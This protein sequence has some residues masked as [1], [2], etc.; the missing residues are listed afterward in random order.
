MDAAQEALFREVEEDLRSEQ[1][2]RL[3]KRFGGYVIA[4]AVTVVVVV[5]GVEGWTAWQSSVRTKE[6]ERYFT[7]SVA[8]PQAESPAV[9]QAL[10]TLRDT[11]QTGY[12]ALAG[13]RRADMLANQGDVSAAIQAYDA[14]SA[15]GSAPQAVRDLA[16]MLA[17]LRALDL[18]DV[19]SVRGRLRPMTGADNPWRPLAQEM[20]ALL[21]SKDGQ[22]A[23]ARALYESLADDRE[24][25]QGVRRRAADMLLALGGPD[26]DAEP[27]TVTDTAPGSTSAEDGS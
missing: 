25:P 19:D 1:L 26:G 4:A 6:A 20:L 17:A 24:A 18:E 15:D 7:A 10:E 16:S 23:E 5:A 12:A 2:L 21:A 9:A 22:V 13:L 11:G 3:W 27:A 14:L 8:T